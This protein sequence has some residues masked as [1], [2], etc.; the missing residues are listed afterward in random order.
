[1]PGIRRNKPRSK[2]LREDTSE[3]GGTRSPGRQGLQ[4]RLALVTATA[5]VSSAV[6]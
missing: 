6:L 3:K 1:M 2:R 5:T 4:L